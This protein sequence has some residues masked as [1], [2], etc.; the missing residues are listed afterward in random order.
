FS[1]KCMKLELGLILYIID[2]FGRRR[3]AQK[4]QKIYDGL[5]L[6]FR[7]LSPS[8]KMKHAEAKHEYKSEY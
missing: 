4:L 7:L 3:N 8:R 2:G 5:L 6:N 1:K